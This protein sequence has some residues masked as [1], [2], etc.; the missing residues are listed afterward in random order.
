VWSEVAAVFGILRGCI[1]VSVGSFD[2]SEFAY[3]WPARCVMRAAAGRRGEAVSAVVAE[4]VSVV[5]PTVGRDLLRGCV[6]SIVSGTAWPAELIVV[7]QGD[8]IQVRGWL[9]SIGKQGLN[10][11]HVV[12]NQTGI[13]AATNRGLELVTTPYVATTHDDCRVHPTWL[14]TLAGRV[15]D[16]GESILTG[17]VEPEGPGTV[18]TV[19]T[20]PEAAVYRSP[21]ID[22]T[23]LFPA[24]MAFPIRLLS[25]VGFLDEHPSLRLAGEDNEWAYRALGAGV[26][27]VYD[28]EVVVAHLARHDRGALGPLYRRYARGQGSFYGKYLRRGDRFILGRATRDLVRAP[29][30]LLR[31]V[32]TGNRDLIAMGTGEITGLLPGILSG[33]RNDGAGEPGRVGPGA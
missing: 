10:V 16:I 22:R 2:I 7:D 20:S 33:L 1:P 12:S 17:R 24:N 13:A 27:I 9:A 8:G 3:D 19:I 23:V 29:W 14:E 6:D 32:A 25:K 15:P 26:P 28:P 31:G 5:I 18:L 30:L 21:R 4:S 11:R